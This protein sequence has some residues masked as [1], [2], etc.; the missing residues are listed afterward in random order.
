[1]YLTF[2]DGMKYLFIQNLQ[3][4][5]LS[6]QRKGQCWLMKINALLSLFK[7]PMA[8]HLQFEKK[9]FQYNYEV[10]RHQATFILSHTAEKESNAGRTSKMVN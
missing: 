7:V 6:P 1:M 9:Q 5:V 3:S 8:A 10:Q 4:I 2:K